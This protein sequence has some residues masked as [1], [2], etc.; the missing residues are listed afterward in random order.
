MWFWNDVL[1]V[2]YGKEIKSVIIIESK[3]AISYK[4][5]EKKAQNYMSKNKIV[6]HPMHCDAPHRKV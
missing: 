3:M 5:K 6:L 2:K 4:I 1:R